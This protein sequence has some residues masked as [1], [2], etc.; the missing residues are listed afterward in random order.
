MFDSDK[1]REIQMTPAYDSFTPEQRDSVDA[2]ASVDSQ[3]ADVT[4]PTVA[5]TPTAGA[6]TGKQRAIYGK[7]FLSRFLFK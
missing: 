6:A 3:T 2:A 1:A 5:A 7:Q 4:E